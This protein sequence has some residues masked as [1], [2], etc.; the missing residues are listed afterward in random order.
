LVA[1]VA[2]R[3]LTQNN[4]DG[5]YG[6]EK[7]FVRTAMLA[8]SA[9]LF[10]EMWGLLHGGDFRMTLQQCRTQFFFVGLSLLFA[11][12][13]KKSQDIVWVMVVIL[14]VAFIRA[15]N[16]IYYF[17]TE[18]RP[19]LATTPL[20]D[21]D[22][23]YVTTHSDATLWAVAV[24]C[25][26]FAVYHL[27]RLKTVLF[28]LVIL[29]VVTAAILLNNRRIAFVNVG[30][31]LILGYFMADE[32]VRRRVRR[33]LIA[34]S[35]LLIVYFVAAWNA[36][37]A[38]WARPVQTLKSIGYSKDTSAQTRDIENYNLIESLRQAP[39][40]GFGY[41][42]EYIE[43]VVGDDISFAFPIYRFVPHN[44]VLGMWWQ[45]G[46]FGFTLYWFFISIGV[47]L[48]ARIYRSSCDASEKV[49]ALMGASC[50]VAYAMQGFG[51]MGLQS[52][53]GS[54]LLAGCLGASASLSKRIGALD[55]VRS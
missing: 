46:Y 54:L 6:T 21:G 13:F 53:M 20:E 1:V 4:I 30:F 48:A 35:P 2:V 37:S 50:A 15:L 7:T 32:F 41:G 10:A 24:C 36:D 23:I 16:C 43:R 40:L 33:L 12:A 28:A 42:R 29:P 49:F 11:Y 26:V 25:C 19:F 22:G 8:L 51:D 47:F 44:S 38:S 27:P 3:K 14:S 17:I 45:A 34:L 55:Y 39:Y 52:T 31:G 5:S 9:L 18:I